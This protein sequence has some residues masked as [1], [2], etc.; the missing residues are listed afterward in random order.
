MEIIYIY[1]N[2]RVLCTNFW[3]LI[4]QQQAWLTQK[5]SQ[6]ALKNIWL[7][8]KLIRSNF[9]L[10]CP[11]LCQVTSLHFTSKQSLHPCKAKSV[12]KKFVAS[13]MS[14]IKPGIFTLFYQLLL[15]LWNFY[16]DSFYP[17]LKHGIQILHP[18]AFDTFFMIFEN[19]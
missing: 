4:Y 17:Q 2:L 14:S 1:L 15:C 3:H 6:Y 7:N 5:Q 19:Q 12:L 18:K 10:L 13:Q 9:S 11:W 16:L 8:P